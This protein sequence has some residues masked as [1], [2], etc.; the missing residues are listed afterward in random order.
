MKNLN[1]NLYELKKLQTEFPKAKISKAGMVINSLNNFTEMTL[2]YMNPSL[3][4]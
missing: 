1:V 2:K 3:F 4:Y